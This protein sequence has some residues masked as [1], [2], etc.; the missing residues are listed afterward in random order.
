M[1]YFSRRILFQKYYDVIVI[2]IG[3][4]FLV[5]GFYSSQIG[6]QNFRINSHNTWELI[7]LGIL[8]I[9]FGVLLRVLKKRNIISQKDLSYLICS[10]IGFTF[11]LL[12]I[13]GSQ[14]NDSDS[15]IN[16]NGA[17]G[18]AIGGILFIALG[19]VLFL[20]VRHRKALNPN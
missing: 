8:F 15:Q 12:G 19:I 3:I 5:L 14:I 7:L 9:V 1:Q 16:S 18:L 6:D 4:I 20:I 13:V 10:F 11:L 2:F 17:T